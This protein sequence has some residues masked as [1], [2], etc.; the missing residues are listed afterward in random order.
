[1]FSLE[2]SSSAFR[3]LR[4]WARI[5]LAAIAITGV[6]PAIAFF[7]VTIA[8]CASSS[9]GA[10]SGAGTQVSPRLWTPSASGSSVCVSDIT[11]ASGFGA[12]AYVSVTTGTAGTGT[13]PGKITVAAP[14]SWAA[15]GKTLL[16]T[17][18]NDIAV[19]ASI[20]ATGASGAL[21]LTVGA[22]RDYI[23]GAGVQIDLPAGNNFSLG[24]NNFTVITALGADGSITGTDLQG[25]YGAPTVKY[26]LG[27]DIDASSTATWD[28]GQGFRPVGYD[29]ASPTATRFSGQFH[30]LGHRIGGLTINRPATDYVGLFGY[31][32]N[33]GDVR[34]I[35]LTGGSV[36][37][38]G[39]VGA[40][41]GYLGGGAVRNVTVS[42][43]VNGTAAVGAFPSG[44]GGAVGWADSAV[45]NS[46]ASGAVTGVGDQVGGLVGYL[47]GGI[48]NSTAS[49]TVTGVGST[50]GLVGFEN[51]GGVT[52]SSASGT[53][54]STGSY[55]GGLIGFSRNAISNSFATGSVTGTA[56]AGGLI[57][58]GQSGTI[59]NG[60]ATGPVSGNGTG[61]GGLV[62]AFQ[63]TSI[64]NSYATGSVTATAAG[65]GSI[66]GFAG[67]LS[68]GVLVSGSYA[69]GTVTGSGA[70]SYVAGFVGF[71]DGNVTTSYT[72]STVNAPAAT[73]V[74][75]F[76]GFSRGN[77]ISKS[78]AAGNVAG[79]GYSGGFAG[80]T[81]DATI[82]DV[83][84]T[85]NVT[86]TTPVGG[87]SAYQRQIS[88][89][90]ANLSR[91]YAT[92]TLTATGTKGGVLGQYA[93]GTVS[94][95]F[96]S[97]ALSGATLGAG[98]GSTAG[99]TNL[100]AA[101]MKQQASFTGFDFTAGTGV[102][103]IYEGN[104]SPLLRQFLTPLAISA[105]NINK[106]WDGVA[107]TS[108]SNVTYNPPSA[109]GSPHIL[110]LGAPYGTADTTNVGT[111][112]P[113]LYS[114]QL[115]FD[116]TMTGGALTVTAPP[117][118]LDV[119][120]SGATGKYLATTDGLL[121]MRHLL[122]LTGA[123]LSTGATSN[124]AT[125]NDVLIRSYLLNVGT[126]LDIDANGSYDAATDGLLVMRYLLG[127]RGSAL[128]ADAV[129]VCPPLTT[130]RTT[131]TD[132]ENYLA[133]LV[134]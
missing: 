65:A 105:S 25:M 72:T 119:D 57:G 103:R 71:A 63:G 26:A 123:A 94:N 41:A 118:T 121:I 20:S 117:F 84:A 133:T 76:V 36:T 78:F 83:Y 62:G 18:A 112:P 115:G 21:R 48:T 98:S 23:L 5:A 16:L 122:G 14:I 9:G 38:R 24:V 107:V 8:S 66:G 85:G 131:A 43:T 113:Q 93:S 69:S 40:V 2:R 75:G 104:T 68:S 11:G 3:P 52:A 124:T 130:C 13:E 126:A 60:Y 99:T 125:R 100:S 35:T 19:N 91:A 58:S 109:A 50:G 86:G 31:G 22:T 54:I 132:I 17:A 73:Y 7:D 79:A 74:A 70:N 32:W 44:T 129:G 29:S 46:T 4:Q 110:G 128:I 95:T 127:F 34:D 49:G 92:G 108:L 87:V 33:N 81:S 114:D 12:V 67:S 51:G 96:W 37:G 53:V 82:S 134:P 80:F 106:V 61:I 39:A 102:W 97:S 15:P 88:A 45:N 10:W 120:A 77:T 55:T 64:S 59:T 28:S 111:Y 1:M 42:T 101:Q 56:Y 116:I 89:G 6:T 47:R 90:L 27:A 30:G